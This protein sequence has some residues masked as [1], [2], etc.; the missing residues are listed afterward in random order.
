[1]SKMLLVGSNTLSTT[2]FPSAYFNPNQRNVVYCDLPGCN[3]AET[4]RICNLFL[5]LGDI[6]VFLLPQSLSKN[7]QGD[8]YHTFINKVKSCAGPVLVCINSCDVCF[9]IRKGETVSDDELKKRLLIERDDWR[10]SSLFS[11][12]D[13]PTRHSDDLW[14]CEKGRE[15]SVVFSTK[16]GHTSFSVWLT[17]FEVEYNPELT[18]RLLF[19]P[20]HV[21][22]WVQEVQP[23]CVLKN[24]E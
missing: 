16:D 11:S 4:A 1:M 7:P 17:S 6:T 3:D 12:N 22:Q 2:I 15:C 10:S 24:A 23:L 19:L 14:E 8:V 9:R 20:S 13:R 21:Q 5:T 18:E